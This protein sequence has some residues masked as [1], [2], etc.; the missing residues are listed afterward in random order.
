MC[1]FLHALLNGV[2]RAAWIAIALAACAN[3]ADMRFG[4]RF[5]A[6]LGAIHSY[7][8]AADD[9]VD[10]GGHSLLNVD[11]RAGIQSGGVYGSFDL[12][13]FY[14]RQARAL[15][16]QGESDD[17]SRR[18]GMA[19][20]FDIRELY[21]SV[22][23]P[24]VDIGVGRRIINF[25]KGTVFSPIDEFSS[26]NVGDL[27]FRRSGADIIT[28][29]VPVGAL[30]GVDIIAELPG[31]HDEH[32]AAIKA[33]TTLC[34]WD[35]SAVGIYRVQAREAVAGVSCKGDAVVGLYG[36]LTGQ[37][38][39]DTILRAVSAMLGADY[40]IRNRLFLRAE[41]LYN[42]NPVQDPVSM[43]AHILDGTNPFFREHYGYGSIRWA[44]NDLM[45]VSTIC[46]CNI[47]DAGALASVQYWYSL[48]Q[49]VSA[50][51]YV[52][53][54]L[55]PFYGVEGYPGHDLDY[56]CRLEAAF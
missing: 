27:A 29:R 16:D 19:A 49:N 51:L 32:S 8:P 24:L 9:H 38:A 23:L 20:L 21:L 54:Y 36:E 5:Y 28:A 50:T 3:G 11:A 4:G 25:G 40:S 17:G 39:Q 31:L 46:I 2:R 33:F 37:F 35:F 48:L 6:D 13:T 12:A 15:A 45:S 47:L 22:Y 30:S 14:G 56:G 43:R 1:R 41:Y 55:D 18:Q 10:F 34:D 53:G 44:I 26:I 7:E 52:R 42:S